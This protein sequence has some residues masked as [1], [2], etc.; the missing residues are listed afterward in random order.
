MNRQRMKHR[1]LACAE[2]CKHLSWTV[3]I[4][5]P[6][7]IRACIPINAITVRP[8]TASSLQSTIEYNYM[9]DRTGSGERDT[10]K[11]AC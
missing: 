6:R 4:A 3:A 8:I 5:L 1:C 9:V 10:R 2:L 7:C 11:A